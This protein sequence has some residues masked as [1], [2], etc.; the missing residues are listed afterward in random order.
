MHTIA[1]SCCVVIMIITKTYDTCRA[2]EVVKKHPNIMVMVDHCGLP[3]EMDDV[4]VKKW[5]E[6]EIFLLCTHEC[7]QWITNCIHL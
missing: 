1:Q 6:G 3:Y 4:N 2:A 5:K 7:L